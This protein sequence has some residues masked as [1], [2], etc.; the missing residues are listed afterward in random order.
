MCCALEWVNSMCSGFNFISGMFYI[1][2]SDDFDLICIP[3]C[4]SIYTT[5]SLIRSIQEH[6]SLLEDHRIAV[7]GRPGFALVCQMAPSVIC[8]FFPFPY[9]S[10][11]W[12]KLTIFFFI[13]I[14]SSEP[15]AFLEME[16][17]PQSYVLTER[18]LVFLLLLCLQSY[19]KRE[20][21]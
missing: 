7:L 12:R 2:S 11:H 17:C 15:W 5:L 19:E 3:L 13:G 18:L 21:K 1:I 20:C 10:Q 14:P 16:T 8:Q 9:E 4:F 6:V